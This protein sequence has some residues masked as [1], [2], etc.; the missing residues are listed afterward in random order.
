MPTYEAV[1]VPSR[2]VADVMR[3]V[4]NLANQGE[5]SPWTREEIDELLATCDGPTLLAL[6]CLADATASHASVPLADLALIA[7]RSEKEFADVLR[8]LNRVAQSSGRANITLPAVVQVDEPS[9]GSV[10]V[11]VRAMP[12]PVAEWITVCL[13]PK[14]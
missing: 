1:P 10:D 14:R 3:F 13:A 8:E 6:E 2:V 7:G 5:I 12:H 9:V 4:T 11:K